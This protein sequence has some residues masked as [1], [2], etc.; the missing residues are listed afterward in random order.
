MN[1]SFKFNY[2]FQDYLNN[3]SK[4]SKFVKENYDQYLFD[5][6]KLLTE[7]LSLLQLYLMTV[8]IR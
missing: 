5:F 8:F 6:I 7:F 1:L 3:L 2:N 4:D